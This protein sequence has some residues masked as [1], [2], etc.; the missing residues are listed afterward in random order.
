V[1]SKNIS[2]ISTLQAYFANPASLNK[3]VVKRTAV[4][5]MNILFPPLAVYMLC[6][7]GQDL[8]FNSILFLLAVI[9]SHV[10]GFYLS[11]TYFNRKRKAKR[12]V[13]PGSPKHMI[14][15]QKVQNGGASKKEMRKMKADADYEKSMQKPSLMSRAYSRARRGSKY[16]YD[17]KAMSPVSVDSYDEIP[18]RRTSQWVGDQRRLTR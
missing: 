6:G 13:Y 4:A 18:H 12:G 14:Y 10:H 17:E 15:S 3:M 1:T 7:A 8:L 16:D 11:F 9:P 5:C 2:T